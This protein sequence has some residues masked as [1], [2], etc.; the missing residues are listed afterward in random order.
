AAASATA[1]SANASA[2]EHSMGIGGA[3]GHLAAAHGYH[4][5]EGPRTSGSERTLP[6]TG[7][8]KQ[9]TTENIPPRLGRGPATPTAAGGP[10]PTSRRRWGRPAS[11]YRPAP[12]TRRRRSCAGCGA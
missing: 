7:P 3:K 10:P 8:P 5:R 1:E 2:M 9:D 4:R 12:R 6:E 11:K